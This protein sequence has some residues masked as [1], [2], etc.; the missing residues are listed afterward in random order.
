MKIFESATHKSKP[1]SPLDQR[2]NPKN[3]K[4]KGESKKAWEARM[5][6]LTQVEVWKETDRRLTK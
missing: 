5:K 1:L 4:L 6:Y 2:F 3:K